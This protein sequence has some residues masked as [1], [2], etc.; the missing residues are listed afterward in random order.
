[1]DIDVEKIVR[2]YL[3]EVI[4]FSLG[5]SKDGKPWVCDL[6][7]AFDEDLN[8][9]FRST[10][11]RRHSQDIAQNPNVAGN[12]TKQVGLG[13]PCQGE[14]CFEGMA[15]Q[16][17]AGP[18]LD[19][20]YETLKARLSIGPEKLEEAKDLKGHQFYKIEVSSWSIFGNYDGQGGKKYTLDWPKLN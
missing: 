12:M 7:Y 1:M 5:T 6:H 9:Y 8:L 14:V 2:E 11:D 16:L 19:K 20:A 13:E 15:K 18:E 10:T 17:T 3:P 4:H